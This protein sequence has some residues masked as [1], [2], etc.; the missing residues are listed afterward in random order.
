MPQSPINLNTLNPS[1]KLVAQRSDTVGN[2][3]VTTGG[4]SSLLNAAATVVVK[5]GTGRLCKVNVTTAGAAGAIYDNNS[6]SAGNTAA[7]LIGVI[8][9]VVGTYIFDWPCATGITYAPGASQVVS[10]SFS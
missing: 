3:L 4:I 10:I 2:N 5:N 6:T 9:A 7:N 8:P 1:G